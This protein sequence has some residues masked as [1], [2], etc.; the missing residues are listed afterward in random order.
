MSSI[1][2]KAFD[3]C[4]GI[5]HISSKNDSPIAINNNVFSSYGA[6]LFVPHKDKYKIGGWDNFLTVV[7]GYLVDVPT[8]DGMTFDC[9]Q[10]GD[11]VSVATLTKSSTTGSVVNVPSMAS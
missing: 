1:G 4:K 11:S 5:T 3:G 10:K 9:V 8:Y 6:T 2:E 7:E